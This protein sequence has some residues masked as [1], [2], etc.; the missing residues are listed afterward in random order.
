V[1]QP[2]QLWRS[3]AVSEV[4]GVGFWALLALSAATIAA[5]VLLCALWK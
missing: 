2:L 3:A 5:M 4:A 1:V